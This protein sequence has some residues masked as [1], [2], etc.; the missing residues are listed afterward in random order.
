MAFG[1]ADPANG[2]GSFRREL[3]FGRKERRVFGLSVGWITM[4]QFANYRS[5]RRLNWGGG[6][7]HGWGLVLLTREQAGYLPMGGERSRW[8][9][10]DRSALPRSAGCGLIAGN[11]TP[12]ADI[13]DF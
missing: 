11:G 7:I 10:V 13:A 2:L 5:V 4:R 6:C 12:A 8:V 1:C 3:D 9:Q